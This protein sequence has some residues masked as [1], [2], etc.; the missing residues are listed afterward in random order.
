VSPLRLKGINCSGG[1]ASIV[2]CKINCRM[3]TLCMVFEATFARATT[4]PPNSPASQSGVF[5][6]RLGCATRTLR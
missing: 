2:N 6:K 5:D 3:V 1:A 4:T